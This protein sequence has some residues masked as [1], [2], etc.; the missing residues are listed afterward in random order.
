MLYINASSFYN[1]KYIVCI[2]PLIVQYIVMKNDI[3]VTDY[4][5]KKGLNK[6]RIGGGLIINKLNNVSLS[7]S[8]RVN[9]EHSF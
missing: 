1:Y 8:N 9:R 5:Y 3:T 4:S 6:R 7:D 2:Y